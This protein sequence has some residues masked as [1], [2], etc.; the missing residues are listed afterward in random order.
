MSEAIDISKQIEDHELRWYVISVNS[1]QESLVVQNLKERVGKQEMEKDIVDYLNPVIHEVYY[2]KWEKVIKERKLYPG[3]IFVKSRM[4]EKIWYIIRN[5]PG[6]RL[7][8]WAE[9][10]P[11][12]LT[13]KEYEDMVAYIEEKNARA[14]FAVPFQEW[15]V[16]ILRDGD[17]NGMQWVI[18]EIDPTKGMVYASVEIL[19]RK[20]PVMVSFDKVERVA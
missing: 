18:T 6:V 11:I 7:I 10:R 19:W 13:D 20:T 16:V 3:Y 12:P 14:E 1:G 2:K 8:V 4:N 15:D 17:F 9:I 5:T